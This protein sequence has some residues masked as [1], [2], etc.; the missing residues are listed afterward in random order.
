MIKE[1]KMMSSEFDLSGHFL[2]AMPNMFDPSFAGSLV[3]LCEH[4]SKGAMGLV[5]SRPMKMAVDELLDRVN[6]DLTAYLPNRLPVMLGGPIATDRGFVLHSSEKVWDASLKIR[7]SLA[8]TTSRDVLEAVA[9]GKAPEQWL[10]TLGYSGWASGQLEQELVANVWLTVKADFGV[11]FDL[12]V[13]ERLAGAYKLLGIDPLML[14]GVAG[15][16]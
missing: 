15:H 5:V 10:I 14:A 16:A 7:D 2:I 12:P 1:E 8:L 9:S 13:E 3:Y 11:L 6:L 4:S